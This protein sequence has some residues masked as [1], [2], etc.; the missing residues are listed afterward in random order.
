MEAEEHQ[1]EPAD[2][3]TAGGRLNLFC[4]WRGCYYSHEPVHS[5]KR[6]GTV[7]E[8]SSNWGLCSCSLGH[9]R[10]ADQI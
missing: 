2:A 7:S 1:R 3:S 10:C 4:C 8:T 5:L 6:W 9:K